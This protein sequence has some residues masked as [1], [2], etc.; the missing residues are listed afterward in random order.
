MHGFSWSRCR[1]FCR[2]PAPAA[3][4]AS[5]AT[6]GTLEKL[7]SAQVPFIANQGQISRGDVRYYARTLA[8]TVFVQGDGGAA[9]RV[10]QFKGRNPAQWRRH[11]PTYERVDLGEVYPGITV[12]LRAHGRNVEKRFHVVPGADPAQI[13]MVV[14]GVDALS[15][16]ESGQLVLH[17][18]LVPVRF[19][20]TGGQPGHCGRAPACERGL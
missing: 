2:L 4:P 3:T 19:T 18:G 15:V 7:Y 17:T 9:A 10:S 1:D 8:G 20:S 12:D 5:V 13:R 16:D 11:L 14:E 6:P